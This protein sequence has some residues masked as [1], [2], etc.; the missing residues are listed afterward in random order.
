MIMMWFKKI[1]CCSRNPTEGR[2]LVCQAG[3]GPSGAEKVSVEANSGTFYHSGFGLSGN[4]GQILQKN[5]S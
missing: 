5:N 3:H 4:K 1:T 2:M